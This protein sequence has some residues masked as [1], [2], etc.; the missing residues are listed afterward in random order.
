MY[1]AAI[2]ALGLYLLLM[3]ALMMLQFLIGTQARAKGWFN[4][5]AV[6][7]W[8][9]LP[10]AF[11]ALGVLEVILT[12]EVSTLWSIGL[13]GLDLALLGLNVWLYDH[14][15]IPEYSKQY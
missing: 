4:L 8:A 12:F 7:S 3:T 15:T 5:F 10:P 6:S 9:R 1:V 11:A 2:A 13:F 14:L